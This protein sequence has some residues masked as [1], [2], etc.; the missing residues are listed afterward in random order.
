MTSIAKVSRN[1]FLMGV[2][3]ENS[4]FN[5]GGK[6]KMSR[7]RHAYKAGHKSIVLPI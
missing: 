5:G 6:I 2:T 4:R 7:A 1:K 3:V